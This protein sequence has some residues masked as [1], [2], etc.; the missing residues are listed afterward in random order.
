MPNSAC[1]AVITAFVFLFVY[2][3]P[4]GA[5]TISGVVKNF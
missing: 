4:L 2:Q 1:R 3:L 5:E